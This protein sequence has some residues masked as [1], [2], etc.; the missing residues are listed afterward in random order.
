MNN[1]GS[2]KSNQSH[3]INNNENNPFYLIGFGQKNKERT[4]KK[5]LEAKEM[6]KIEGGAFVETKKFKKSRI[7]PKKVG[8][9]GG[10]VLSVFSRFWTCFCFFFRFGRAFEVQCFEPP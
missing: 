4:W 9:R 10:V 3:T 8:L 1:H 2:Q 6:S 7:V 5:E